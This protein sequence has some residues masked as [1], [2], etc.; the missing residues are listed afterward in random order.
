[1]KINLN[2]ILVFFL[3]ILSIILNL[4]INIKLKCYIFITAIILCIYKPSLIIPFSLSIIC[5]FFI[6]KKIYNNDSSKKNRIETFNTNSDSS[7]S[8]SSIISI[9]KNS[10]IS[11][12]NNKIIYNEIKSKNKNDN[13]RNKHI[14]Y[15]IISM[16]TNNLETNNSNKIKFARKLFECYFFNLEDVELVLNIVKSSGFKNFKNF[17]NNFF[18]GINIDK[19]ENKIDEMKKKYNKFNFKHILGIYLKQNINTNLNLNK[20]IINTI[21]ELGLYSIINNQYVYKTPISINDFRRLNL[22]DFKDSV[23]NKTDQKKLDEFKKKRDRL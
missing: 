2:H 15:T 16:D 9:Y 12:I 5:L 7:L 18:F 1:M 20:I 11:F 6:N 19:L 3:I 21:K 10:I 14:Y 17:Y 4:N 13:E 8:L 23:S 22:N